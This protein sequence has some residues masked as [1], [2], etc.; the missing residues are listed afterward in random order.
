M[1]SARGAHKGAGRIL[2]SPCLACAHLLALTS[3]AGK[4][5][6][7]AAAPATAVSAAALAA[8]SETAARKAS[9]GPSRGS[10]ALCTGASVTA[11]AAGAGAAVAT[12]AAA[13]D[14]AEAAAK[15]AA[16]RASAA[17]AARCDAVSPGGLR[18]A[19]TRLLVWAASEAAAAACAA[20]GACAAACAAASAAACAAASG[21]ACAAA[22]AAGLPRGGMLPAAD[23]RAEP[24]KPPSVAREA[25]GCEHSALERICSMVNSGRRSRSSNGLTEPAAPSSSS[26]SSSAVIFSALCSFSAC[27]WLPLLLPPPLVTGPRYFSQ[28]FAHSSASRPRKRASSL[29]TADTC[30]ETVRLGWSRSRV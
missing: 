28:T 1:R 14:G 26:S 11:A 30:P 15:K 16:A 6:A 18:L 21:A 23:P 2:S 12:A 25:M 8:Y 7:A 19:P 29:G 20:A 24:T 22:E 13:G 27:R 10:Q 5:S 3:S 9:T 17:A 4:G